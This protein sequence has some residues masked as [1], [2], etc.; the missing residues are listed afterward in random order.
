MKQEAD[1]RVFELINEKLRMRIGYLSVD[2]GFL[3]CFCFF[4]FEEEMYL[5][6]LII[7]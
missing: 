5:A 6:M 1:L 3:V 4:L 7:F 2:D